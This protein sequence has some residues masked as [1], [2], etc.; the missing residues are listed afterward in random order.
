MEIKTSD[1]VFALSTVAVM[2]AVIAWQRGTIKDLK[3]DKRNLKLTVKATSRIAY[4][5]MQRLTPQQ[6]HAISEECYEEL[7]FVDIVE[8]Y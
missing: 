3:K 7:Q 4:R 5:A 6:F 8:N 2:G 1:A